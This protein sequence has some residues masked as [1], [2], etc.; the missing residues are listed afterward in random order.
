MT[1]IPSTVRTT[2]IMAAQPTPGRWSVARMSRLTR[3]KICAWARPL[4]SI[5]LSVTSDSSVCAGRLRRR[6]RGG[7]AAA[8][9]HVLQIEIRGPGVQVLQRAVRQRPA[10]QPRHATRGILEITENYRVGGAGLLTGGLEHSLGDY[11]VRALVLD[12]DLGGVDA[13][14]TVG[15]LLHHALLARRHV[16]VQ[17]PVQGLRPLVL[18]PVEVANLVRAVVRAVAGAHAPVVD[19]HVEAVRIVIRGVYRTDG[20]ARRRP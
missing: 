10:G 15:A 4:F 12:G 6:L 7:G 9:G 3:R 19:L 13:L 14:H 2:A 18:E 16:R 5:V 20:L 8:V 1:P 17:P 11:R